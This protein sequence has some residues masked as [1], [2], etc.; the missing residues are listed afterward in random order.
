VQALA[1][2]EDLDE[3]EDARAGLS[4]RLVVL[5]IAELGLERVEEALLTALS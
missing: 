3:L 5:V 1:V 2:V 4:A